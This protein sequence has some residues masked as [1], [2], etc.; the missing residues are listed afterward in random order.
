[1]DIDIFIILVM[2]FGLMIG[3]FLNVCIYRIPKKA[4]IVNPPSSCPNCSHKLSAWEN[5]PLLSFLFLRGKCRNC[6]EKISWRYPLIEGL[7]AWLFLMTYHHQGFNIQFV[8]SCIFIAVIIV[9]TLIDLDTFQI[10]NGLLLIG[11]IPGLISLSFDNRNLYLIGFLILGFLYFLIRSGGQMVF[12][13]EAMGL[14]DVK[15]A[16]VIGLF[17]GWKIGLMATFIAFFGAA[18][19]SIILLLFGKYSFGQR[20]PFGPFMSFG[21]LIGI[22]WGSQ[23]IE[24]YLNFIM[25]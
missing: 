10:P 22:F 15:Y 11:L 16:S 21:A 1:M 3:S 9:I 5:I 12:R 17:L 20:I 14:G 23:L 25:K 7:T 4:S 18:I 8:L 2:I 6:K 13:K 19:L 24:G